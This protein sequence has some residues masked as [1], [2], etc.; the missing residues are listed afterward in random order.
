MTSMLR[1]LNLCAA[2]FVG[3]L[4]VVTSV[5]AAPVVAITGPST[6]TPGQPLLLNVSATG[7]TDLYAYQF[8]VIFNPAVF[9][10]T[11]VSEG[12]FLSTVG[13]TFFDGGVAD[14]TTGMISFIFDT[15]IGPGPGASGSGDLAHLAFDV[16]GALLSVG[17]FQIVNFTA[18][19][20]S[21]NTINALLQGTSVTV[22]E[23]SALA[24]VLG[25]L[26]LCFYAPR[27]TRRARR[28]QLLST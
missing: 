11:G 27:V 8:D 19:D 5:S 7:F 18:L 20:S 9:K 24:L 23:P 22:P 15:L 16:K 4:L 26:G 3:A 10:A 1:V 2:A 12:S 17:S 14:N 21:F 6:I 13:S 25:A 28:V